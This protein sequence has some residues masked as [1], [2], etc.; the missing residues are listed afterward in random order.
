MK[1][2]INN[3]ETFFNQFVALKITYLLCGIYSL[4]TL[5]IEYRYYPI[6]GYVCL[7]SSYIISHAYFG[8]EQYQVNKIGKIVL[9]FITTI[10]AVSPVIFWKSLHW[11]HHTYPDTEKDIHSPKTGF[12]NSFI[13][14]YYKASSFDKVMVDKRTVAVYLR[15]MKD[16]VIAFFS[17]YTVAINLVFVLILLLI[18]WHILMYV[19]FAGYVLDHIR[20]GLVNSVCHMKFPGNYRNFNTNDDSQ[21]NLL[22][23]IV[24]FGFSW[25]NNHHALPQQLDTKVKWWE[26]DM[27]YYLGRLIMAIFPVDKNEKQV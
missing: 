24:S 2:R 12:L 11:Y 21:N 26:W 3:K 4:A 19:Y 18:N 20:S 10:G 25:H 13:L 9:A 16:P 15:A 7:A 27:Q 8:H 17:K 14:W 6:I 23:G 5:P 1:F 22:I